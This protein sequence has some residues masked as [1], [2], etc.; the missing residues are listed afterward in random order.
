[1]DFVWSFS[2]EGS[3]Q[4]QVVISPDSVSHSMLGVSERG[5]AKANEELP[6]HNPVYALSQS[7]LGAMVR[8]RHAAAK[9]PTTDLVQEFMTAVLHPSVTVMYHS[10]WIPMLDECQ[11]K[12][13]Y[14][15]LSMQCGGKKV[16]DD[17]S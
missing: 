11:F 15:A 2:P 4:A 6:L 5:E 10:G 17:L 1:M 13:C 3:V 14:S 9:F 12:R 16:T 7:I 8:I